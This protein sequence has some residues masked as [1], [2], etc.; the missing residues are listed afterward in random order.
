MKKVILGFALAAVLAVGAVMAA[1]ALQAQARERVAQML[2]SD[3]P[4][5]MHQTCQMLWS[6]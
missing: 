1:P 4:S 2:W 5:K 3:G 6:D